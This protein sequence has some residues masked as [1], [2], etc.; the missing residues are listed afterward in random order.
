MKPTKPATQDA[1]QG[2]MNALLEV[3]HKTGRRL[4][5]L[6]AGEV[7]TATDPEGRILL[8]RGIRKQLNDNELIR[9]EAILNALPAN[10]ALLDADGH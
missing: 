7:D 10:I 5:E 2:E 4:E 6:T 1:S 9:Q 3:L 8:L